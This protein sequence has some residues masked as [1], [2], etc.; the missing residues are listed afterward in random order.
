M[1]A[2]SDET[3]NISHRLERLYD[4]IETGKLGLDDLAP[5]IREL[6][7]QQEKLQARKARLNNF[8]SGRRV[9]LASPKIV[10]SYTSDLR[11]LLSNSSLSERKAF[12]RSFVKEVKVTGDDVLITYTMPLSPK[13]ISE[14]K[15]GVLS[16]V[17]YGGR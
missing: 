13:G 16:T 1:D 17:Q 10:E 3:I 4:A 11:N 15:V 12:I 5:R 6:R 14:E 9:E 2:V 8:L 7:I